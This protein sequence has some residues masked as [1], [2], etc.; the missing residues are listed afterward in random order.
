M[1]W[2]LISW[3]MLILLGL[4]LRTALR[5]TYGAR[6]PEPDDPVHVLVNITAW[7]LIGLGVFPAV[8][9]GVLTMVGVIV[10]VLA[11]AT[12]VELIVHRRAARRR[13]VCTLLWWM[14]V[15]CVPRE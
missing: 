14:I 10:L 15:R 13:S 8:V 11:I 1:D 12:V 3:P 4:G 7:V 5:L 2:I 9:F 6:G